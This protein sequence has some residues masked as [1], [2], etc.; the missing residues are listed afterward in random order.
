[1]MVGESGKKNRVAPYLRLTNRD[2]HDKLAWFT[3]RDRFTSYFFLL[4]LHL[5]ARDP[6]QPYRI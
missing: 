4:H 1:M 2:L 3:E 5:L 6:E